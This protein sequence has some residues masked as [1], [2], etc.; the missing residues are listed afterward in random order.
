M[1]ST[2]EVP[3]TTACLVSATTDISSNVRLTRDGTG[4]TWPHGRDKR[5]RNGR[6][7]IG[8]DAER[9]VSVLR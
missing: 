3:A 5:Q 6:E 1:R 8:T 7:M 2:E 4:R 9:S